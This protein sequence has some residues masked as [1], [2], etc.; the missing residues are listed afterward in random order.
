MSFDLKITGG[1]FVIKNGLLHTVVDSEKL[2]Q[3][4]LKIC[5]TSAGSNP[6]NPAYGSFLSRTIVGNPNYTDVLVQIGKAQLTTSLDSLKTL[7]EMQVQS[8]QRVSADEQISAI[9]DI[10]IF[11]SDIDPRLFTVNIKAITKG[12]KP[13]TTA[14]RVSTI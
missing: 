7:Q 4:I 6:L 2:I 8:F 9:L 14:F 11:R 12:F 1:D 3:D 5:L 13:I 10:S